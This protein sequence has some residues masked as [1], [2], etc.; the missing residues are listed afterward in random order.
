MADPA[1]TVSVVPSV[2]VVP[3]VPGYA[4]FSAKLTGAST[5]DYTFEWFIGNQAVLNQ[6]GPVYT[7]TVETNA[8]LASEIG[9]CCS[10]SDNSGT[11]ANSPCSGDNYGSI[12]LA[13]APPPPPPP[14]P[15]AHS[16]WTPYI[17]G[18]ILLAVVLYALNE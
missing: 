6:N 5:S 11:Q 4:T 9:V 1:V 16:G 15:P 18:G 14:P 12:T 3:S 7:Y 17:A 10:P 13:S 2:A 8:D